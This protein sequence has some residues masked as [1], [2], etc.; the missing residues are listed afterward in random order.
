MKYQSNV[1]SKRW[2]LPPGSSSFPGQT[3]HS[4]SEAA[5]SGLLPWSASSWW[6][7]PRR[8]RRQRS[9]R[10]TG[11]VSGLEKAPCLTP[12][13]V[14]AE[15]GIVLGVGVEGP[16]FTGFCTRPPCTTTEHRTIR[17]WVIGIHFVWNVENGVWK[18][19]KWNV[20]G[21]KMKWK[22]RCIYSV[23][24]LNKIIKKNRKKCVASSASPTVVDD[25]TDVGAE[26][27]LR[28]WMMEKP[29][30]ATPHCRPPHCGWPNRA[31]FIKIFFMTDQINKMVYSFYGTKKINPK[32]FLFLFILL[33][34]FPIFI[35]LTPFVYLV[36]KSMNT[37]NFSENRV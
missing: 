36:L 13:R 28:P 10:V 29:S 20:K 22:M 12:V 18:E 33:I 14:H 3:L 25:A 2:I 31:H 23:W 37:S 9:G 21:V 11:W 7:S 24:K 26:D 8:R 4:Q 1:S 5:T 30:S 32:V 27:A 19:W 16:I 17:I 15:I 35:E 34:Q 6:R